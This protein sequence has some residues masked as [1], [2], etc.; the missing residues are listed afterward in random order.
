MLP[1]LCKKCDNFI[2]LCTFGCPPVL[3]ETVLNLP[4]QVAQE[5]YVGHA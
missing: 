5:L 1:P 3:V 2:V 4:M